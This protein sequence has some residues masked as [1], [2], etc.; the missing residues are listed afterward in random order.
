MN[1]AENKKILGVEIA[2][3]TLN[4]VILKISQLISSKGKKQIFY[5]NAHCLTLAT[6]NSEYANILNKATLVYSGGIGPIIASHILG[7]PLKERTPTPDFINIIFEKIQRKNQSVY[8]LGSTE[9]SIKQAVDNI[10]R[11]YPKLNIIG[12]HSGYFSKQEER[13]I[14]KEINH[15]RPTILLV[16]MG[17]PKQETWI[18]SNFGLNVKIFWAVGALFDVMSN[19]IPRA[20]RWIQL[21]GLEWMYRLFQEP[22][23]LWRRYTLGNIQFIYSIFQD[24]TK[25]RSFR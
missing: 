20:P 16:G 12:F 13:D 1:E 14:V 23:R 3:L 9:K 22:T 19:T 17:S 25:S 6:Q 18:K 8:F 11:K 7:R 15:L 24:L 2:P 5:V 21:L 4:Q 10:R